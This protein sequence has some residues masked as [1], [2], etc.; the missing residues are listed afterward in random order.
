MKQFR[1]SI[2]SNRPVSDDFHA[3]EFTWP[4]A[5][6]IPAPGQ[7]FTVR[8]SDGTV[9]FLRRPFAFSGFDG[10]GHIASAIYKRRGR[11][12]EILAAKKEGETLDVI[13]P[14]GNPFM[15]PAP[16]CTP[17]LAAG[18]IGLGPVLF[19]A[20][21]LHD[22][23]RRAVF[24][25]GFRTAM[26]IVDK[27]L[28]GQSAVTLCTDDGSEGFK[29]TTVDYIRQYL[30][31]ADSVSRTAMVM[32]ACGPMAMLKGCHETA[33]RFGVT[34]YVS[35]EQVMACGVGACMGCVVKA[36]GGNGYVRVCSDGPVFN[37]RDIEWI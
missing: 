36:A 14:S 20:R 6:G 23:G 27:T 19:L 2:V 33:Q 34:C 17:V 30:E 37:S 4:S 11:G 5:A 18:G 15:L 35:V 16:N 13:G 10:A 9:P 7:F 1:A 24:A 26:D 31:R 3:I 22:A 8:V 21:V 25:A 32:Y 28:F 29:G 12:T